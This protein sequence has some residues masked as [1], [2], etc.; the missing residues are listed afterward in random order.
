MA[1]NTRIVLSTDREDFVICSGYACIVIGVGVRYDWP[2]AL[3]VFGIGLLL[4]GC[5]ALWRHA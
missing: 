2:L 4:I 3:I 5:V 1:G